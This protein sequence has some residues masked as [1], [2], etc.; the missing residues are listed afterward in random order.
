M[1]MRRKAG[2]I[3]LTAL[4]IM[5]MGLQGLAAETEQ[6]A[7]SPQEEMTRQEEAAAEESREEAEPAQEEGP[8][9][10]EAA[11]RPEEKD[12][13]GETGVEGAPEQAEIPAE[14]EIPSEEAAPQETAAE[15]PAGQ[16][17]PLEA[18]TL[19]EGEELLEEETPEAL[20]AAPSPFTEKNG[21]LYY[22][23]DNKL[24][25]GWKTVEGKTYYFKPGNPDK[26]SML[27]GKQKISNKWYY[28]D[29]EKKT[30]FIPYGQ[31]FLYAGADGILKTGWQT[32]EGKKYFFWSKTQK[33]HSI[34]EAAVGKRSVK[35]VYHLFDPVGGYLLY[36][37][38]KVDGRY[39]YTDNNGRLQ[40]GLVTINGEKYYFNK[41]NNSY[42]SHEGFVTLNSRKYLCVEGKIQKGLTPYEGELY[43]SNADGIVQTGWQTIDGKQYYFLPQASASQP[44]RAA[45]KGEMN[46]DDNFYF[47][48]QNGVLDE[49]RTIRTGLFEKDG[50]WHFVYPRTEDGHEAGEMAT[51]LVYYNGQ[52]YL[53]DEKGDSVSGW[54]TIDGDYAWFNEKGMH[55]KDKAA[56]K[57][58]VLDYGNTNG[59]YGSN[60][61]DPALLESDGQYLLVDTALQPGG[62]KIIKKL[63]EMGVKRLS[64]YVSHYHND[65][66]GTVPDI[67]NDSYFTVDKIYLEDYSYLYG[68]DRETV[69]FTKNIGPLENTLKAAEKKGVP[70]EILDTGDRFSLGL[71]Q[72]EV[73][74]RIPSETPFTG[75]KNSNDSV[76]P[77]INDMSL[78]TRFSCG[79]IR[80]LHCGDLEKVG[81]QQLLA[82]NLDLKADIFKLNHHGGA[83]S[84][85][86]A[87][88]DAVKPAFC[89][90]GNPGD[91]SRLCQDGWSAGNVKKVQNKGG[92]V[93]HPLVNGHTTFS[94]TGGS[95]SVKTV[96][97]SKTVNVRVLNKITKKEETIKVT[98]QGSTNGKYT[99]HENMIPFYY[100]LVK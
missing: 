37:L 1:R 91:V 55:V 22:Y 82:Q 68:K 54:Q 29:P 83:S 58:T 99:I 94:V 26:G 97:R 85:S 24:Q 28:L 48:D 7:P 21:K 93:F 40:K 64:I 92:N 89:Y 79:N 6:T 96:R 3:L 84:N 45:V 70:V 95:I 20:E 66:T 5:S 34:H 23:I 10:E 25:T 90:Y 49:S 13:A 63:K 78:C 36:G 38:H 27:T 2:S 77:Y 42:G 35:K 100:D 74:Y 53:F 88:I 57:L 43:F 80:F 61:G 52:Y 14:Q 46:Q 18:E 62:K 87:L 12:P 39:Y 17:T 51:G 86:N 73:L 32:I 81:E 33:G 30:G 50:K 15:E 59:S 31:S 11:A 67:L 56:M 44:I 71:V 19:P 75:N 60:Y 4:L 9:T 76:S 98:V 16:E 41:T 72:A 8:A 47:F 69:H 65:H